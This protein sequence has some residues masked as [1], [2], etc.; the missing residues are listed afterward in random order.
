MLSSCA[1]VTSKS[2]LPSWPSNAAT[3][4]VLPGASPRTTP[5]ATIV[6]TV[7]SRTD[8]TALAVTRAVS[9]SEYTASASNA[10]ASP[11]G[12]L[13]DVGVTNSASTTGG[14]TRSVAGRLVTPLNVARTLPVPACCVTSTPG[15]GPNV[16]S[17]TGVTVQVAPAVTSTMVASL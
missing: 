17:P 14:V 11:A 3:S 7:E 12:T 10:A 5:G 2:A 15:C 6:A 13:A 16:P 8:H 4:L 9:P 1:G